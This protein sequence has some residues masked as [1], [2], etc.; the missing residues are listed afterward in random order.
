MERIPPH[1][2]TP[3]TPEKP[4][5][6]SEMK[7]FHIAEEMAGEDLATTIAEKMAQ[8]KGSWMT[9][10]KNKITVLTGRIILIAMLDESRLGRYQEVSAEL[11]RL[12]HKSESLERQYSAATTEPPEKLKAEV[13]S[14]LRYILAQILSLRQ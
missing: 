13:I 9:E 5:I 11:E 4:H 8:T 6:D 14:A 12:T 7:L 1:G 10:F 3:H 2:H